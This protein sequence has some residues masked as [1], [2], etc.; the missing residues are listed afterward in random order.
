MKRNTKI[1]IAIII[2]ALVAYALIYYWCPNKCNCYFLPPPTPTPCETV[3][4]KTGDAF[5]YQ[6]NDNGQIEKGAGGNP[7]LKPTKI[8]AAYRCNEII[9]DAARPDAAGLRDHLRNLCFVQVNDCR[10][11][12]QG[13][14]L[15]KYAGSGNVDLI[16]IVK[17]PPPTGGG[18]GGLML[19][20]IVEDFTPPTAELITFVDSSAIDSIAIPVPISNCSKETVKIAIV[21]SG[22]DTD[23]NNP[24]KLK[25]GLAWKMMALPVA[26]T[27]AI[28]TV[29]GLDMDAARG[30]E[31][32]DQNGHGTHINGI[33]VGLSKPGGG[34]GEGVQLE[35]VN[36]RFTEGTKKDG[37]LFHAMCGLYYA[38][39]QGAEV[40]NVSWGFYD[41]DVPVML[42][43]FLDLAKTHDVMVVAGMGNNKLYLGTSG[44]R[45]WPACFANKDNLISV[46][47]V[48]D[49]SSNTIAGFSN[50]SLDPNV[51]TV[52]AVGQDVVSTYPIHLSPVGV[53]SAGR[54]TVPGWVQQSGTSM[55][56]PY[57]T[58]TVAV[59]KGIGKRDATFEVDDIKYF[60]QLNASTKQHRQYD[61]AWLSQQICTASIPIH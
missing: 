4:Y 35:F 41:D 10:C 59:M 30:S 9:L 23:V 26:C 5:T 37:S 48:V 54:P 45:F 39:E 60:I 24:L 14:E 2:L 6:L 28:S 7:V 40:I 50:W 49:R 33:V 22:V 56:A 57:V 47:A 1:L 55:A 25:A 15:W 34:T 46:G 51:M 20:F 8:K 53:S 52:S 29:F 18:I 32:V 27:P 3:L 13:P 12:S 21:D 36:A 58:R 31:P 43:N 38:L 16:G 11:T 44:E 42:E 61:H 19:N 17:D